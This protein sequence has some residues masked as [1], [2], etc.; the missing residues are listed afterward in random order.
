MLLISNFYLLISGIYFGFVLKIDKIFLYLDFLCISL[1]FHNDSAILN[2]R[3][4]I[5]VTSFSVS[6]CCQFSVLVA[7]SCT[8]S[9]PALGSLRTE[10]AGAT[11]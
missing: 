5:F 7:S 9:V 8:S 1:I 6:L 2:H 3:M 10:V 11:A 4:N